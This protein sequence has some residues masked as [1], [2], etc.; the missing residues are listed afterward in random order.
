MKIAVGAYLFIYILMYLQN[1]ANPIIKK[2]KIKNKIKIKK[3]KV[4][5]I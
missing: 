1:Q 5:H 4:A 2:N 3:G